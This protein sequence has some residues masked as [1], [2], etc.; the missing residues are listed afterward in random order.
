MKTFNLED[1]LKVKAENLSEDWIKGQPERPL[2]WRFREDWVLLELLN[3]SNPAEH[4]D[5]ERVC[6][7]F[8]EV[9]D[10]LQRGKWI[11]EEGELTKQGRK[12][13]KPNALTIPKLKPEPKHPQLHIGPF[14]VSK[15][16]R[17]DDAL[18]RKL[19]WVNRKT[20]AVEMESVALGA[21]AETR[22]IPFL[23]AKGVSDHGDGSK[24]DL[25]QS[26]AAQA[27]ASFL[28]HLL[29]ELK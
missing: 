6:P 11:N 29:R 25:F 19:K 22:K 1:S 15:T 27:S 14:G 5:L 2:S 7:D 18:F 24:D 26:Y 9:V 10:R 16:V 12:R 23:V 17:Q 28:L 21:V 4:S 8:N 13:L 3:G 20:I